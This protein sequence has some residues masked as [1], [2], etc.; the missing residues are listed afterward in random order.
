MQPHSDTPLRLDSASKR[1]PNELDEVE[2]PPEALWVRGRL[3]F[4]AEAPRIAIV[5]TRSPTPYGEAQAER[6]A[7]ELARA[8]AVIVSGLARGIDQAAHRGALAVG[9]A[10]IAVLGSGVDRPWPTGPATDAVA[11]GGLLLSEYPPGQGPRRHHFPLRNRLISGLSR[12]VLVV[13]AAFASGS[14]ITARWAVDQ[15]K[16]VFALP[17]RVDHPLAR[18]TLRLLREGATAVESPEQLLSD[19]CGIDVHAAP[20][21]VPRDPTGLLSG[22]RGETLTAAE[23]AGRVGVPLTSVLST[24]VEFELAG[25]VARS[26]GGL[27]RLV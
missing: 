9:G 27:Y 11:R 14:L 24:L 16:H 13:E 22:L 26:P 18:G 6:F 21:S 8:G 10:T 1:W 23:L 5:G 20:E 15:G 12:G 19:L 3:A 25:R 17:G 7:T 4:L 2:S